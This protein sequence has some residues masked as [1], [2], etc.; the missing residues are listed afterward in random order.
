MFVYKL[1]QCP[2]LYIILLD[3]IDIIMFAVEMSKHKKKTKKKRKSTVYK[4]E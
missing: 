2:L 4:G 1:P 3:Y